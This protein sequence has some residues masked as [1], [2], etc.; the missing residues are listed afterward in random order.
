M[1]EKRDDLEVRGNTVALEKSAEDGLETATSEQSDEAKKIMSDIEETRS[2]MGETLDAIQD[3]LSFANLSEQVSERVNTAMESAKGAVYD[4]TIGRMKIMLKDVSNTTM[5]RTVRD[6]AIPFGLI[7]LGAGLLAYKAY[8]GKGN[9]RPMGNGRARPDGDIGEQAPGLMD[10]V[11]SRAH[12]A[13]GMVSEKADTAYQGASEMMTRGYDR[14]GEFSDQAKAMYDQYIDEN[15]LAV[16]ALAMAVG[17]VVG[18]A[19]P[20]SRYEGELLG[21]YRDDLIEKAQDTASGLLDKTKQLVSEQIAP[22]T[23]H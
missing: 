15:P 8:S 22:Q 21:E 6:N 14:A 7:G 9:R 4:A 11:S 17:A 1:A 18:M 10:K 2:H 19:I 13:F 5:M 16:G 3:R 20:S 23:D 12:D